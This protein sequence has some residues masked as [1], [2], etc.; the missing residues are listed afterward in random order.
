MCKKYCFCKN[1]NYP[2]AHVTS[3]HKCGKCKGFGHG[4]VEC[5]K[6]ND[7]SYDLINKLYDFT[8]QN[9]TVEPLPDHLHCRVMSC[10]SKNTHSTG[11]HHPFFSE[12]EHGD[13][14]MGPDKYGIRQT[15]S[16]IQKYGENMVKDILN[17]YYSGYW[18]QGLFV[19]VRNKNNVIETTS[20]DGDPQ[21]DPFVKNLKKI[22]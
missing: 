17:S 7:D 3:Y 11:S 21:N 8:K 20:I 14:N 5:Y 13:L 16:D 12:D 19:V 15:Y 4:A 2:Q 10:L 18:G 6:N 9:V 22:D 1:C